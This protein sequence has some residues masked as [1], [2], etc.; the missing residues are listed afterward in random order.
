MKRLMTITFTA[1]PVSISISTGPS[2]SL[3]GFFNIEE[4]INAGVPLV[5]IKAVAAGLL[6]ISNT[7]AVALS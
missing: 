1:A 6:L 7:G 2:G 5:N 3:R 4:M